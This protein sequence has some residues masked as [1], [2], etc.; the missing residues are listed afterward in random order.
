MLD[1]LDG[2]LERCPAHNLRVRVGAVDVGPAARVLVSV[3]RPGP[4]ATTEVRLS[5]Q[6]ARALA[7]E[8][9]RMAEHVGRGDAR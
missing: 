1:E 7:I 5:P 2:C 9:L 3:D 6:D 8:I 4:T